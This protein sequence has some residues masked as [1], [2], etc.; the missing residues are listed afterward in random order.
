MQQNAC[1]LK[2]MSQEFT[3]ICSLVQERVFNRRVTV[4]DVFSVQLLYFAKIIK[5][6]PSV[7][8]RENGIYAFTSVFSA[9]ALQKMAEKLPITKED[10][11]EI[12]GVT[13]YK[14]NRFDGEEFLN[15]TR[16]YMTINGT[17]W[18]GKVK[19]SAF[20]S[21]VLFRSL[22]SEKNCP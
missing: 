5:L 16:T 7:V 8:A 4:T 12:G 21:C 14:F 2:Q 13:E 17:H 20:V 15:I 6:Y 1:S 18:D 11:L 9:E 3:S 19:L 22:I 10:M